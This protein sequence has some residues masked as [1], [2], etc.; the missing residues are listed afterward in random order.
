[1]RNELFD[2]LEDAFPDI[3]TRIRYYIRLTEDGVPELLRIEPFC[4]DDGD[5]IPFHCLVFIDDSPTPALLTRDLVE[6]Q[7][8]ASTHVRLEDVMN[9][10]DLVH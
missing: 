4:N 8:E 2:G 5:V 10:K 6:A 9:Y 1:M 3:E 7:L